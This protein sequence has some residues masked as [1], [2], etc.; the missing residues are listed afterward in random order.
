M[1]RQLTFEDHGHVLT[2]INVWSPDSQWIV[3]DVRSDAA[4]AVFDGTQI[5]RVHVESGR[6]ETLYASQHGAK[7]G[8]VTYAPH[9]DEVAFILGPEHPTDDWQYAPYHRRGLLVR[10]NAPKTIRNLEAIDVVPPFTHGALRGGTHVHVYSPD[11]RLISFTYEDHWLATPL[12]DHSLARESNQ[13]NVGIS[14]LGAEVGVPSIHPRNQAGTAFSFLVTETCDQPRPGSDEINR[15]YEDAWIGLN[16][17]RRSDGTCQPYALAFLGDCIDLVGRTVTEIYVVDLPELR[18]L[19][20]DK[21]LCGTHDTR[22][23][24]PQGCRQRRLTHTQERRYPG[25]SLPRHW[26]RSSPDGSQIATLM[27]NDAGVPQLV[28][29]ATE[30]GQIR[31]LSQFPQGVEG[32]FTW[33]PDGR[34]IACMSANAVWRLDSVSGEAQRLTNDLPGELRPEACVVSPD[35]KYV[36]IV[37]RCQS[38]QSLHNQIFV[39]DCEQV[40]A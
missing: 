36:A 33:S 11:G 19:P 30:D 32:A 22:P 3:Y 34:W 17:Y 1:V 27:K 6:V 15:A 12:G 38:A 35:G 5:Q 14:V 9:L 4:G 37:I 18:H 7:C 2:N 29:V 13:R 31:P 39:V 28:L 21:P 40:Y 26:P 16:G 20:N 10:C 23:R 24:P 8:V 25:I